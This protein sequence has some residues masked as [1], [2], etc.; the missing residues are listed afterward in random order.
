[1]QRLDPGRGDAP[2]VTYKVNLDATPIKA[3]NEE[4]D[5]VDVEAAAKGEN[6]VNNLKTNCDELVACATGGEQVV[7]PRGQGRRG[8]VIERREHNVLHDQALK[9]GRKAVPSIVPV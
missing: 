7:D 1:M 9:R 3:C 4:M 2:V 6:P 5:L 8:E